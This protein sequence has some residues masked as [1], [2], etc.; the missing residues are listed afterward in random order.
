ALENFDPVGRWRRE[1]PKTNKPVD[2]SVI[3]ADG[4]K[5]QGV[6]DLKGWLVA[7]IDPFSQCVAEKLMTYATG[8]VPNYAERKELADIVRANRESAGGFRDLVLALIESKTFRT[9]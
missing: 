2:A 9:K 5:I 4:T 6:V 1:W 7:N 8:R 3:L